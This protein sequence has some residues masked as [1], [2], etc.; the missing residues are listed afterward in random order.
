LHAHA[1]HGQSG[2]RAAVTATLHCLTGCA[3]GEVV[4]MVISTLAGWGNVTSIVVSIALAFVFGYALTFAPVARAGVGL[5]RA[6][7]IT[8]AAETVSISIMEAV[9]NA[10]VLAVPG[11]IDAGLGDAKFWWSIAVG[12][13]IAFG[14]TFLANRALI[15]RGRGHA[16]AH[17][18]H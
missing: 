8:I 14:P 17:A 4:G 6:V 3:I 12:F 18:Y 10:F 5:R 11:A 2:E 15:R 16:V 7:A 13:A 1:E 9:D